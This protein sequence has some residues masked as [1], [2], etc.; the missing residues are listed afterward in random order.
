MR[1]QLGEFCYH[2]ADPAV[3]IL[4]FSLCWLGKFALNDNDEANGESGQIAALGC[5]HNPAIVRRLSST[6]SARSGP[7]YTFPPPPLP[8]P[9][10]TSL[11]I[12]LDNAPLPAFER[13]PIGRMGRG[14]RFGKFGS[15]RIAVIFYCSSSPASRLASQYRNAHSH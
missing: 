8:P 6:F 15:Q 4:S 3:L 9:P 10:P 12:L 11:G 13:S 2:S 1:S 5:A 14:E 7:A